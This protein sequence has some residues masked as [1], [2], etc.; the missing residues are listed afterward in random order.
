MLTITGTI[1]KTQQMELSSS[2]TIKHLLKKLNLFS[3]VRVILKRTGEIMGRLMTFADYEVETN[4]IIYCHKNY[5]APRFNDF[6]PTC[7][8]KND[9]NYDHILTFDK[10]CNEF[11]YGRKIAQEYAINLP[12]SKLINFKLIFEFKKD[13]GWYSVDLK[14]IKNFI[15]LYSWDNNCPSAIYSLEKV[16]VKIVDFDKVECELLYNSSIWQIG[17]MYALTFNKSF[18]EELNPLIFPQLE[19]ILKHQLSRDLIPIIYSYAHIKNNT[20]GN[21]NIIDSEKNWLLRAATGIVAT[22]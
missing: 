7:S 22:F 13:H 1:R 15:H 9:F 3:D 14:N 16:Q 6:E 17:R 5:G 2:T 11:D 19:R 12:I 4:D 18:H 21:I 8:L 10:K 20:D